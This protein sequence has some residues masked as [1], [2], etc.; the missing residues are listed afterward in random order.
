MWSTVNPRLDLGIVVTR[1]LPQQQFLSRAGSPSRVGSYYHRIPI[2][3]QDCLTFERLLATN[4]AFLA[5]ARI[6]LPDICAC[7]WASICLLHHRCSPLRGSSKCFT[8]LRDP[9]SF[10][11]HRIRREGSAA[12]YTPLPQEKAH[13]S[14]LSPAQPKAEKNAR[15]EVTDDKGDYKQH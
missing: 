3:F 5:T 9:Y 8:P 1:P 13:A 14:Q 7:R 10:L 12:V 4:T 15:K 2:L 11:L 6:Y